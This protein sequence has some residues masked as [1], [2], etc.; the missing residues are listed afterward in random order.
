MPIRDIDHKLYGCSWPAE[1]AIA[2]SIRPGGSTYDGR[3]TLTESDVDVWCRRHLGAPVGRTLGTTGHLSTVIFARLEDGRDVAVKIRPSSPR[4]RACTAV[5]HSLWQAG[6]PCPQPLVGPVAVGGYAV[7]AEAMR[8]GGEPATDVTRYAALLAELIRLAPA[9]GT[10]GTLAPNPPWTAWDHDEP[11]LWPSPDDR[12]DDLNR[13]PDWLDE[14]GR[15]VRQLLEPMRGW[16]AVVGHGDW[17]ARNLRWSDDQPWAVHDWDSVVSGPEPVLVGLAAAVWPCGL[18]PRAATVDESGQFIEAYLR[19]AGRAWT[20]TEVRAAWAA[21]LWVDAFNAKK[22]S[23]DGYEWL[24]AAD[25]NDRLAL[26][27][28]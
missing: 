27:G 6:Y 5:Q 1:R 3:V 2:A 8:P 7:S 23:L 22:A 17:E 4:L 28:A 9:A 26:A 15:R 18:V 10:V 25:A 24:A 19:A 21:G 12:A 13:C 11:G 16:P 20:V 14:V